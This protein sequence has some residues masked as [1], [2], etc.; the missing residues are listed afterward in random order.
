MVQNNQQIEKIIFSRCCEEWLKQKDD[1]VKPSSYYNYKYSVEKHI[2]PVL[3]D[4]SL[5][6]LEKYDFKEFIRYKKET[7]IKSKKQRDNHFEETDDINL[8]ALVTK[9]KSILN[10]TTKKYH[11]TFDL[12]SLAGIIY[13][14][15][16]IEVFSDKDFKK[17]SNFLLNSN[18]IRDLGVLISLYTGLRIGEICGLK[19]SDINFEDELLYVNRTAQRVYMGKVEKSKLIITKPKTQKSKRKIPIGKILLKK[20][21]EYKNQYPNEAFI[22]TGEIDKFYEP[23]GYR[24]DYKQILKK[25]KIPYKNYHRLRHSFASRCIATGM[26]AKSLSEILGH[27]NIGI[28]MNLYVHSSNEIKK[29]YINKL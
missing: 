6:E 22:L 8:K 3:G 11:I 4:K 10:Y 16:E 26:D 29:K 21:K 20:L 9:L 13:T 1:T 5:L 14:P 12:E 27:S 7:I 17:L 19:W 28:T 18:D 24:Y 15:S 2:I 25:C 23:S